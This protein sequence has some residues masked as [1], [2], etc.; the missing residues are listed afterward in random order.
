VL[1]FLFLLERKKIRLRDVVLAVALSINALTSDRR[2]TSGRRRFATAGEGAVVDSGCD[3]FR[4]SGQ[5][6][7][8]DDSKG[9]Q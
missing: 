8:L 1:C 2:R 4:F 5:D 9:M 6:Q 3:R 7:R